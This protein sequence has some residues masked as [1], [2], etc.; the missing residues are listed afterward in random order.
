[1]SQS[2]GMLLKQLLQVIQRE[3]L[4]GFL[5]EMVQTVCQELLELEITEHLR[6]RPYERTKERLGYRNGYKP[7]E[8]RTRD[9][10][11][12]LGTAGPPGSG[13]AVL[14]PSSLF[15]RYQRSEK[16]LLLALQEMRWIS[17]E[18][19]LGSGRSERS[20][21]RSVGPNRILQGSGLSGGKTTR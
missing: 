3:E 8:L 19:P 11:G 6:T 13:R 21:K 18:S 7:R 15:A 4:E 9:P 14:S 5:K 12:D 20:S 10:G 1:M 16:A 17:T 2:N